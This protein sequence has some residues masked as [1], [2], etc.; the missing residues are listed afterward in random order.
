[1]KNL[2]IVF[3]LVAICATLFTGCEKDDED[4]SS[5]GYFFIDGVKHQL[6]ASVAFYDEGGICPYSDV[7]YVSNAVL[8]TSSGLIVDSWD[9][10]SGS[11]DVVIIQC[12]DPQKQ[13]FPGAGDYSFQMDSKAVKPF[14]YFDFAIIQNMNSEKVES[15]NNGMIYSQVKVQMKVKKEGDVNE[16]SSS[17]NT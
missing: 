13:K 7:Q 14:T 8:F 4:N 12:M 5:P 16:Y 6:H 3:V 17:G 2:R 10:G 9:S 1:M 15:A 11:G